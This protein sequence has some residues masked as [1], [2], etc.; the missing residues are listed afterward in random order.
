[1]SIQCGAFDLGPRQMKAQSKL[2]AASAAVKE[3]LNQTPNHNLN[4]ERN[5]GFI[6]HE[7][8]I[9]A[10]D[11]LEPASKKMILKKL[12]Y[13]LQKTLH[14]PKKIIIIEKSFRINK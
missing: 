1:M 14:K 10:P 8:N 13:L 11:Q 6:M 12:I 2:A 5:V 7:V 4:E 3:K 9:R